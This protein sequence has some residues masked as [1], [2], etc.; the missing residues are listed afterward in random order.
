MAKRIGKLTIVAVA[1]FLATA[2][3]ASDAP[4]EEAALAL[5]DTA[6]PDDG[7]N[8]DEAAAGETTGSTSSAAGGDDAAESSTDDDQSAQPSSG[9]GE[10]QAA[11]GVTVGVDGQANAG[12]ETSPSAEVPALGKAPD[13]LEE[14]VPDIVVTELTE[15]IDDTNRY[16]YDIQFTSDTP[17]SE[18]C[19]DLTA[20]V[21]DTGY[22]VQIDSCADDGNAVLVNDAG[23]RVRF[24]ELSDGGQVILSEDSEASIEEAIAE[25]TPEGLTLRP[26]D[27]VRVVRRINA[28]ELSVTFRYANDGNFVSYC[29]DMLVE[30]AARDYEQT[31]RA[32]CE[33]GNLVDAESDR[34]FTVAISNASEETISYI[35]TADLAA[36]AAARGEE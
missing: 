31:T 9:G 19:E 18:I 4:A 14:V 15:T 5:D 13:W 1:L 30:I 26:V 34:P 20:R 16:Q 8:Q 22:R 2:S 36:W 27:P 35:V 32:G 17:G 12:G 3:C 7:T 29:E 24:L 10:S 28:D 33:P 23:Q 21:Q 6:S 11:G 25:V